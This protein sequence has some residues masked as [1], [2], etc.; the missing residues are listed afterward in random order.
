MSSGAGSTLYIFEHTLHSKL[1]PLFK[2]WSSNVEAQFFG[3]GEVELVDEG[4]IG[5]PLALSNNL[6]ASY[7]MISICQALT[8]LICDLLDPPYFPGTPYSTSNGKVR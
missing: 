7:R 4:V 5:L 6:L 8:M 3:E 1:D 2:L